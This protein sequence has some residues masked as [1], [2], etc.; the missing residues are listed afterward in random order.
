MRPVWWLLIISAPVVWGLGH[1]AVLPA[2]AGPYVV[3]A[4]AAGA[5]TCVTWSFL[6]SVARA[7]GGRDTCVMYA[8][9]ATAVGCVVHTLVLLG[10]H[11]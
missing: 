1:Y 10:R 11:I 6:N 8:L 3:A 7:A 9:A 4:W 2:H 5:V